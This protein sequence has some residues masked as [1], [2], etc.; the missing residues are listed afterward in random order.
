MLGAL[1]T[2]AAVGTSSAEA[3]MV[4]G[5]APTGQSILQR[6]GP[7]N[8]GRYTAGLRNGPAYADQTMHYPTNAEPPYAA[9]SI[10]PGFV[11]PQSSIINW[12]PFLASHGIVVLTIGTN[13]TLDQPPARERALLDALET[14][15]AENNRPGSPL[16]GKLDLSRL[17]VG[18]WSMGGGGTLNAIQKNPQLKAGMAICPWN[19]GV[20]YSRI[21]VPTLLF[22]G[23]LDALAA[24]QGP[25]FYRSIP[26][27]TPKVSWEVAGADHFYA[28]DPAGR[29][30]WVGAYGLSFLKTFLEGDD[31]YRQFLS[32]R[33]PSTA[34]FE[35]NVR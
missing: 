35:S 1:L 27:S 28:N 24:G 19:P 9:I 10:V 7:Y 15:K 33:G 2:T 32:V 16:N 12:G 29:S 11:S 17:A 30:G 13:S 21:T 18:G 23:T 34:T 26:S 4:R 3:Q 25:G 20:P 6:R 14:I 22:S 31:R 5:D 8:P